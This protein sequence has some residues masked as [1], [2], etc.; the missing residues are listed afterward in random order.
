MKQPPPP[1]AM[2]FRWLGRWHDIQEVYKKIKEIDNNALDLPVK[3]DEDVTKIMIHQLADYVELLLFPEIAN[4]YD[5]VI[6][7]N[8]GDQVKNENKWEKDMKTLI[9][10]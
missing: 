3:G 2:P 6:A 9:D 1:Q 8:D 10:K 7:S 4:D 5:T